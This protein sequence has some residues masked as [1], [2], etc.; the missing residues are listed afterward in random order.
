MMMWN[1]VW[2][3]YKES[4]SF[5]VSSIYGNAIFAYMLAEVDCEKKKVNSIP[6]QTNQKIAMK[7]SIFL[8]FNLNFC[9]CFYNTCSG[10]I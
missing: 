4:Q 5:I 8:P 3:K 7:K 2:V 10:K 9:I 6:K 1:E